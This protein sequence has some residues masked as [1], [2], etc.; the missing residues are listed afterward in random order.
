ML[1]FNELVLHGEERELAESPPLVVVEL[2]DS[3]AVV[4][5]TRQHQLPLLL[6]ALLREL[7]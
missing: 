2:Y 4:S 1:L 5:V 7:T 6:N 3:D